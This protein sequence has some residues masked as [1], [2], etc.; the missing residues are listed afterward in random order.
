MSLAP[1][2]ANRELPQGIA[3]EERVLLV[4]AVQRHDPRVERGGPWQSRVPCSP[5]RW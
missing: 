2:N 4:S 1:I 3:A 5:P